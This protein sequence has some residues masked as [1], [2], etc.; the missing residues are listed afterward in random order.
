MQLSPKS[1]LLYLKKKSMRKQFKN[2][3]KYIQRKK[4]KPK[5]LI[6]ILI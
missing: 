2:N 4:K 3:H 5:Q 1:L 6:Y